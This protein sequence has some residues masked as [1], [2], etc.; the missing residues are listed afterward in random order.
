MVPSMLTWRMKFC[1]T[2]LQSM[3]LLSGDA[4]EEVSRLSYGS[5][6]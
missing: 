2:L 1:S 3:M 4:G 6:T 5:D